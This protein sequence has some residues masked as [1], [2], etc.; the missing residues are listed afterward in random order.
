M[1][2]I[3]LRFAYCMLMATEVSALAQ[4]FGFQIPESYLKD[5]GYPQSTVQWDFGLNTSPAVWITFALFL[6]LFINLM[7]VRVYGEI[8]Y[9]FGTIKICTMVLIIMF[10]IIISGVN[11]NEGK[12]ERFWTYRGKYGFF[13]DSFSYGNHKFDG[14]SARLLGMWTAMTT[15]FFSLQGMFSVSITAAENRRLETEESIKIATRKIALRAITLYAFCVFSV[16]LNVP[17]DD[18][19]I[20]TTAANSIR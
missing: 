13:T 20:V 12:F 7:P 10:N 1:V 4:T 3:N 9:V 2:N 14:G 19:L 11:A 5:H 17:A 15:L 16:G 8:E 6:I 18:E